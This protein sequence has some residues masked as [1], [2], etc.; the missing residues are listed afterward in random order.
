MPFYIVVISISFFA[1]IAGLTVKENRRPP[2]I[3]FPFFLVLSIAVEYYGWKMSQKNFNT[4]LLYNF[5]SLFEFIYYLYFFTY[6]FNSPTIKKSI[7]LVI[8]LYL[9]FTILNIFLLQGKNTFHS[10]TY[11]L[12]CILIV[13]ASI[14]YF[15]FLFRFPETGS[16]TR[17]PFFWI[18]TGL[19]FYYTCTFSLYGLENFITEKMRYYNKVLFLITDLLN[20]LLYTLFTIGFLCKINFR[21]LLRL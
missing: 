20:I 14:A 13:V 21:K 9:G 12:G 15:Y 16:L 1:S 5:F 19:M 18:A 11:V 2:F 3:F 7:L 4:I 17:N 8:V 6:L 10:H